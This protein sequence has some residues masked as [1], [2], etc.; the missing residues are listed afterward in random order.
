[1]LGETNTTEGNTTGG[2]GTFGALKATHR[3]TGKAFVVH[4]I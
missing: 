3:A 4:K 2:Q 1:M